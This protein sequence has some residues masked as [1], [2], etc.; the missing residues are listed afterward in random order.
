MERETRREV[1]GGDVR[2]RVGFAIRAEV[3]GDNMRAWSA[4]LDAAAVATSI[5]GYSASR[6]QCF[7]REFGQQQTTLE[8]K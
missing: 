7:G 8:T 1:D 3:G 5:D 6:E 2:V 4:K